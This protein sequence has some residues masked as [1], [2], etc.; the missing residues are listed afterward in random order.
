MTAKNV[1]KYLGKGYLERS[2]VEFM[3]L[4]TMGITIIIADGDNGAGDLGDPP[5]LADSCSTRLNPDWPS[6]SPVSF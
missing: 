3:K 1:D 2:D 5:M 4:A 6:Q